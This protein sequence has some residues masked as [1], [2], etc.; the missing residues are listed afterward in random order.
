MGKYTVTIKKLIEDHKLNILYMPERPE[1]E[2]VIGCQDVNRPSLALAGYDRYFD[3]ERIQFMGL[4]EIS[5]L[6]ELEP[7]ICRSR[8]ENFFGHRPPCVIITR[9]LDV[10]PCFLEMAQKYEVPVLST[11]EDTSI[12]MANVI[13]YLGTELAERITRHGVMVE[14]Y[15]EGIL[16]TGNSGVGKSETAI[17]LIKRGHRLIADDAVEIKKVSSKT[18]IGAAPDNI[19]HFIEVRGIGMVNAQRIFGVGA[20]KPTEKIDMVINLE[21]WDNKKVYDRLGIDED[22]ISILGI[23]VPYSTIP[24]SPGRNLAIIIEIAAM[25][26]RQK[27]L[28][29]KAGQELMHQLGIPE[30]EP[31]KHI[32]EK[33]TSKDDYVGGF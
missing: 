27:K 8:L 30:M 19:R 32:L 31:E 23:E 18:L 26:N 25:T 13:S 28:G 10:M 22:F 4:T 1:N 5:Y 17:E 12:M 7:D 6:E 16:I 14:V 29:Y 33:W 15:G 20:V 21:Q 9:E 2:L 24:V 11:D 3:N